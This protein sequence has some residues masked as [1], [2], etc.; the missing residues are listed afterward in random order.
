MNHFYEK[1]GNFITFGFGNIIGVYDYKARKNYI[2]ES[3][4]ILDCKM[5]CVKTENGFIY[6]IYDVESKTSKVLL[7]NFTSISIKS[8]TS[9]YKK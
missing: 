1:N 8:I 7:F 2:A 5:A 9:H 3:S 4:N 6:C